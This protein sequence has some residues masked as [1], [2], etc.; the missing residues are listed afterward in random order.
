MQR[1]P[2]LGVLSSDLFGVAPRIFGRTG[3]RGTTRISAK[4]THLIIYHLNLWDM[5]TKSGNETSKPFYRPDWIGQLLQAGVQ[6]G[7]DVEQCSCREVLW[8]QEPAH[9]LFLQTTS[10]II[11]KGVNKYPGALSLCLFHNSCWFTKTG[12]Y[13]C[14]VDNISST[15]MTTFSTNFPWARYQREWNIVFNLRID[16]VE[17]FQRSNTNARDFTKMNVIAIDKG[18]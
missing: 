13:A 8:H 14:C 1:Y 2:L 15:K 18:Q 11:Q 4:V 7:R 16:D 10:L 6:P 3:P 5:R 9:G 12:S 17:M